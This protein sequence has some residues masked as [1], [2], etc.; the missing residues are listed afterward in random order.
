[1]VNVLIQC[2]HSLRCDKADTARQCFCRSRSFLGLL[3]CDVLSAA[4]SL[5]PTEQ[6]V[7]ALLR[8]STPAVSK[9]C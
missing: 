1:M 9:V 8:E 5:L 4:I 6:A 3:L 7:T 2:V